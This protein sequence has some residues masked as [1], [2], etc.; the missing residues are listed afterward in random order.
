MI[1]FFSR[2]LERRVQMSLSSFSDKF[3]CNDYRSVVIGTSR[4]RVVSWV[5]VREF[6]QMKIDLLDN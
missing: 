3:G 6:W 4:D 2:N 5:S 1:L